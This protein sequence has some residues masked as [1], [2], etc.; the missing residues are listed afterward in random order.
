MANNS[1]RHTLSP[2]K[3]LLQRFWNDRG[4]EKKGEDAKE[5]K[6]DSLVAIR[7]VYLGLMEDLT[8]GGGLSYLRED[9][10]LRDSCP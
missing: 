9:Y 1:V 10:R 6:R 4:R 2:N 7:V 8:R 5:E 3:P